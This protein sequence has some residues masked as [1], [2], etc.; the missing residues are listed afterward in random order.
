[1]TKRTTAKRI[2]RTNNQREVDEWRRLSLLI[3]DVLGEGGQIV[4]TDNGDGSITISIDDA[5]LTNSV[6]GTFQEIDVTD[7]GNGTIT[8]SI[9][10]D[11][12]A[13]HVLGETDHIDVT[14][15][16]VGEITLSVSDNFLPNGIQG[17]DLIEIIDDGD[18]TVSL[19]DENL[20]FF[21][22]AVA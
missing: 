5:Y 4:I 22:Q 18:G 11:Y 19:K 16:G 8:I 2:P 10:S 3:E 6:L 12:W 7:N 14:I 1:M 15:T 17:T 21:I 13:V 9:S 20:E